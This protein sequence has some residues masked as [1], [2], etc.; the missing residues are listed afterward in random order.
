MTRLLIFA[1]GTPVRRYGGTAFI[2]KFPIL[3][4]IINVFYYFCI[5]YFDLQDHE[6]D[7]FLYLN[8]EISEIVHIFAVGYKTLGL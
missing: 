8:L 2:Q 7:T 4:G 6:E 5:H 3:F 1:N